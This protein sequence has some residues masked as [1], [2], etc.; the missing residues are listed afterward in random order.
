MSTDK[1]E[2][3]DGGVRCSAWLGDFAACLQ[4][5]KA[6]LRPG[7]KLTINTETFETRALPTIEMQLKPRKWLPLKMPDDRWYFD[8]E[9]ERDEVLKVLMPPNDPSSATRPTRALDCN[10]DAMAG[11][12]AAHG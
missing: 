11:F 7:C 6:K 10:L 8:S 3:G 2:T 1:H 9:A 12:A 5:R 4:K